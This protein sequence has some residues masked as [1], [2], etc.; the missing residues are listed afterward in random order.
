[1]ND[2]IKSV[3]DQWRWKNIRYLF[4]CR[5]KL[6]LGLPV[7]TLLFFVAIYLICH[8][9]GIGVSSLR[10]GLFAAAISSAGYFA[11]MIRL[12]NDAR[13]REQM[14]EALSG[15]TQRLISYVVFIA[16]CLL[17][18]GYMVYLV[19][20]DK[21]ILVDNIMTVILIISSITPFAIEKLIGR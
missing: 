17:V 7:T 11:G 16:V 1:M 9:G 15:K 2:F 14:H 6:W 21:S 10:Y 8:F 19:V 4:C 13:E 20:C 3:R 18:V 5:P 12:A